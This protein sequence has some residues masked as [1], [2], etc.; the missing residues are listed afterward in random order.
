MST[1]LCAHM[2]KKCSGSKNHNK[3][4]VLLGF[5]EVLNLLISATN[6][7]E[8]KLKIQIAVLKK[9]ILYPGDLMIEKK[10]RYK[11]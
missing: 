4:E 6:S 5:K 3:D 8:T 1:K 11:K 9:L 7:D 2:L 10:N